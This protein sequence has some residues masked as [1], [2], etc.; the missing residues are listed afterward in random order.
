MYWEQENDAL[1]SAVSDWM[2]QNCFD[3]ILWYFLLVDNFNLD[4][5]GSVSKVTP[6]YDLFKKKFAEAFQLH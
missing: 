6:S 1:N 5:N 4:E 2:A 3:K